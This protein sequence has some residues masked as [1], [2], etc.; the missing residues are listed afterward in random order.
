MTR[1]NLLVI[2]KIVDSRQS[3][4][5]LEQVSW[6]QKKIFQTQ[7]EIVASIYNK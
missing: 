2:F 4:P 3:G 6:S 1:E 7:Q 5:Y